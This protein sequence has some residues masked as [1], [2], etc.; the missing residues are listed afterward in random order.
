[1]G[2]PRKEHPG[3]PTTHKGSW[4]V[5]W[6]G[7]YHDLG[8]AGSDQAKAEYARL[9]A[10]WVTDPTATARPA[11]Q[12]LVSTLCRDFL[13]SKA[14]PKDS[15]RRKAA[16]RVVNLL[17]HHH[18]TTAVPEFGP[19]ALASWQDWLCGLTDKSGDRKRYSRTSV[20]KFVGIVRAI[21]RWGVSTERIPHE[22]YDVLLTVPGPQ[23]GEAREP[24]VVEPADQEHVHA[25]LAKLRPPARAAVEIMSLTGG[26]PSEVLGI[27]PM[28]V[29]RSGVV[30]LPVAGR[31]NLDKEQVWV[32]APDEHKNKHRGKPRW[33]VFGPR[34]KEI[35]TPLL[36]RDPA[37]FCFDSREA[38]ADLRAEQKAERTARNGGSGGNRKRPAES[39]KRKPTGKYTAGTLRNAVHRACEAAGV[40][41]FDP[42]QLRHAALSGI[43][44]EYGLDAAQH[45]GGHAN[46]QTTKRYAKRSFL[47][48]ARVAR[49]VG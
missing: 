30:T 11:G 21:W 25:A 16:V 2:R 8:P 48:A 5:W 12:Y 45:V 44:L 38:T 46:P 26:R 20:V 41:K 42:Y 18:L 40:P 35:L 7:R 32:Y 29:K 17:L 27:R 1:M 3:K 37:D 34:A 31:V 19:L 10:L 49:E 23:P 43:D 47:A 13:A 36:F 14:A 33:L 15:E 28:D 6:R 4:R 24:K 39:P 22:R 9:C